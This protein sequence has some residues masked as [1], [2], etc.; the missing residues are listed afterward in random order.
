MAKRKE[1]S[2]GISL[3]ELVEY[4]QGQFG[5]ASFQWGHQIV[6]PERVS[7]GLPELDVLLGGGFVP[8]RFYELFG[9]ESAG[10]TTLA[11]RVARCFPHVLWINANRNFSITRYKELGGDPERLVRADDNLLSHVGATIHRFASVVPLIVVDDLASVIPDKVEEGGVKDMGNKSAI[12]PIA[13]FFAEKGAFILDEVYRHGTIVLILNRVSEKINL[14]NP[15][16]FPYK[17]IG[18][19]QIQ[20]LY[21]ARIVAGIGMKIE[22]TVDKETK[23]IGFHSAV[24]LYDSNISTPKQRVELPLIW[25]FGVLSFEELPGAKKQLALAYR[26]QKLLAERAEQ[27][28]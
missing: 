10:K 4:M 2:V 15:Y 26:E 21:A 22:M 3:N 18:G 27:D 7:S 20:S 28:V 9:E 24:T 1:E 5:E 25:R 23:Q 8:G 12:A 17:T 14:Y 13:S 11:M 6:E 16:A 19:H